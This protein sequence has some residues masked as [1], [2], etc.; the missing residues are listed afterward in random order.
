[1]GGQQ[2]RPDAHAASLWLDELVVQA[3]NDM[4]DRP[5]V[6]AEQAGKG[7]GSFATFAGS[8]HLTPSLHTQA[9]EERHLAWICFR[10][11]CMRVALDI[12]C[13]L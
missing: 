13:Y 11:S 7:D 5:I 2:T 1:L 10:S 3:V 8:E 12:S 4:A 9:T 6:T